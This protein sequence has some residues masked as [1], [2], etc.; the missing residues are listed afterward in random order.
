MYKNVR[1]VINH[2]DKITIF[3]HVRPDGDAMYSAGALCLFLKDNFKDKKIKVAGFDRFDLYNKID[4]VSDAFIKDSL[5]ICLDTSTP[6]RIDDQRFSS[7]KYILKIDHHPNENPYGDYSY[8]DHKTGACA[9]VLYYLFSSNQFSDCKVSNKVYELLYCGLLIDTIN[10]RTS[11]TTAKTLYCASKIVENGNL[12]PAELSN[13]C[14][15]KNLDDFYLD[16]TIRTKLQ[17]KDKFGYIV[18]SQK[19]LKKYNLSFER[20]KSYIDSIGSISDL[21]VWA[22]FVYDVSQKSYNGSLRSKPNYAID[23]LAKE[24]DGG[25]HK[26]ACGVKRLNVQRLH[27]IIEKLAL[28]SKK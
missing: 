20:A 28:I 14:F 3:R 24:Y 26:C 1:D 2:F 27:E 10:F 23:K 4:K 7:A 13:R 22:I 8:V 21:N 9:E 11:S 25:G 6:Q 19:D 17:V 12:V 16:A 18:L 5:A 15:D